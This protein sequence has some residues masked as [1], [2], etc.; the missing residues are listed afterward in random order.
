M[1]ETRLYACFCKTPAPQKRAFL[2]LNINSKG[3]CLKILK[4]QNKS[5]KAATQKP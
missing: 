4:T 1:D 3:V 5:N 2:I